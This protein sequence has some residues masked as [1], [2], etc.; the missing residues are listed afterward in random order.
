MRRS[1]V[2]GAFVWSVS[3]TVAVFHRGPGWPIE[4]LFLLAPLVLVPLAL[5]SIEPPDRR[6]ALRWLQP[7]AALGITFSFALPSG[8]GAAALAAPWL[9]V[10]LLLAGRGLERLRRR[11]LRDA[12]ELAIDAGLLFVPVGAG[13]LVL[14]RLGATPLGFEEPIVLLTAVHFHYAAFTTLV[15][16]G[17]AGRVARRGPVYRTIV[18]AAV[19]GTPVLAAGI[20]LSRPLE[21]AGAALLAVA[22]LGFAGWSLFHLV[23]GVSDTVARGLLIASALVVPVSMSLALLY[24]WGHATGRAIVTLSTLASVHGSLNAFGFGLCA[25]LAWARLPR[26][27]PRPLL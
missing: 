5:H 15:L 21:M 6:R 22:L 4:R 10:T 20:T 1:A 26:H 9:G 18:A 24:A 3:S 19:A 12:A 7:L 11:G 23:P 14:S 17:L 27:L 16:L 13:W 25:L 2:F 8:R